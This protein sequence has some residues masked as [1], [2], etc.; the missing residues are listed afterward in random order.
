VSGVETVTIVIM[1]VVGNG[2]RAVTRGVMIIP[3]RTQTATITAKDPE[4][5]EAKVREM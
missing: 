4:T 5:D 2:V 3:T 1:I